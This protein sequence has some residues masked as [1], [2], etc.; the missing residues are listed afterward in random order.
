MNNTRIAIA[1]ALAAAL[2]LPAGTSQARATGQQSATASRRL[3]RTTARPPNRPAPAPR[4]RTRSRTPGFP[5]RRARAKDHRRQAHAE[6][7]MLRPPASG[8]ARRISRR[9]RVT[10]RRP[11]SSKSTPRIIWALPRRVMASTN[12]AGTT[13][14]RSMRWA[15]RSVGRRCG[16][17]APRPGRCAGGASAARSRFGS[18]RVERGGGR[19]FNDLLPLPYTQEAL[20]VVVRNVDRVQ[21]RLGRK[22]S[23]R[24][25]S[26]IWPSRIRPCPSRSSSPS[27]PRAADAA[28][29]WT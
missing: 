12:S 3:A 9:S 1:S 18:S 6:L 13:P 14:F 19:Y 28:C 2:V 29:C 15:C 24:N 23:W 11:A 17:E 10:G 8:C 27:L 26:A 16:R 5:C 4:R 21:E 20:E 25:P 7:R 22:S